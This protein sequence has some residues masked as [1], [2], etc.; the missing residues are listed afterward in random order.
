MIDR[1]HSQAYANDDKQSTSASTPPQ[2]DIGLGLFGYLENYR[3][4]LGQ[5]QQ[6]DNIVQKQGK[7]LDLSGG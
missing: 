1:D 3:K 5:M 6:L 4:L 2:S 7:T